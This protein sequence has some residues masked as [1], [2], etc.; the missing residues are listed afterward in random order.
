MANNIYDF[1]KEQEIQYAQPIEVME[2]WPWNMKEHIRISML[3]KH[4]KFV[5]GTNELE[6]KNPN[7]NIVYPLLNLRY[8]AEDIDLKDVTLYIDNPDKYHLSFL[9]KKYHDDVYV[10]EHDLDTFFDETKEEKIDLGGTI[11]RKGANGPLYEPLESIAFCDQ[12]DVLSG[13]IGFKLFY[14]PEELYEKEKIGWGDEK[15]GAT[16]SVDELITLAEESKNYNANK[17]QKTKTP[18]KYIEVYRVHG[19]FS[20]Q[21]L[22]DKDIKTVGEK[23]RYVRQIHI[24]G[25]YKNKEGMD[26]GVTLYR[27]REYSNPFKAHLSGKKIRNRALAYGGVEELFDSQI[28]TN[29]S[30]IQ[31][32]NI[33][34]ALSKV[35]RWTTD[36]TLA[37]RNKITDMENNE[38]LTIREGAQIG[39]LEVPTANVSL[40]N[41][42]LKEWEISAQGISG[43]TDALMGKD[44]SSGSPFSLQALVVNQGLGLHEYRMGK[45]ATFIAEIYNDWIIPDIKKEITRGKTFLASLSPDEMEYVADC[46]VRYETNKFVKKQ[47]LSGKPITEMD[48]EM[49]MQK[50]RDEFMRGGNKKFLQALKDEF[51]D[52]EIAV[53]VNVAGKQKDLALMVEKMV[54]IFRQVLVNPQVLENPKAAKVFNKLIEYSGLD[55]IDFGY[56]TQTLQSQS[57]PLQPVPQNALPTLPANPQMA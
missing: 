6:N 25:F 15:Y 20:K 16:I 18:G 30:E 55:P 35:I 33:L 28:W 48:R 5:K 34:D 22:S 42:W 44:P 32:R 29:Y 49:Y 57:Q 54:N 41:E 21:W 31:K 56:A 36:E 23:E 50:V 2:N 11:V 4:G 46:V 9:I 51:K 10:R 52:V 53:K 1:I 7:K 12:T 3:M 45:F 38:I 14:S 8:R 26:V 24:V 27:A 39:T 47:V 40:F 17:G 43:A 13:P 19:S 37:S